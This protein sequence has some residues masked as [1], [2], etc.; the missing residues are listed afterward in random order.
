MIR[1]NKKTE[2]FCLSAATFHQLV[3]CDYF[4]YYHV[5]IILLTEYKFKLMLEFQTKCICSRSSFSS[6]HWLFLLKISY[7]LLFHTICF[8]LHIQYSCQNHHKWKPS[9]QHNY[10]STSVSMSE[11]SPWISLTHLLRMKEMV[12][13]GI[14][15]FVIIPLSR[16]FL[17][18]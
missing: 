15:T 17:R 13:H 1:V 5:N 2:T 9:R 18:V 7:L 6:A 3:N 4:I 10:Q 14:K 16:L 11:R 12:K 8:N